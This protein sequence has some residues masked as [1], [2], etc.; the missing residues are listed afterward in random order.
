MKYTPLKGESR[1]TVGSS[2]A[3]SAGTPSDRAMCSTPPTVERYGRRPAALPPPPLPPPAHSMR[4]LTTATGLSRSAASVR[5]EAPATNDRAESESQYEGEGGPS[6][7]LPLPVAG[8]GCRV[9]SRSASEM[10][11]MHVK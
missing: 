3:Y 7:L 6:L 8:V 5:A 4:V 2:P 1:T 9:A 11:W 10:A